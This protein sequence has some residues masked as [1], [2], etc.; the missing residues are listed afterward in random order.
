LLPPAD[1]NNK[2]EAEALVVL[3]ATWN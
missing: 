1:N 2:A 3:I